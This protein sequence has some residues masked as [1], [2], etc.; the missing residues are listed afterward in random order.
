MIRSV[1]P[2]GP[3]KVAGKVIVALRYDLLAILVVA[4]VLLPLP[5]SLQLENS[6]AALSV[7]GIAA[8]V[9]IAFRNTNAYA[10]WWEARTLWGA[11]INDCRSM[12]NDLCAVDDGSPE[13][14]AVLDRMRRCQVR[15]AW[16]LAAELRGVAP[17]PGVTD[18][19]PEDAADT[20]ANSLLN[21]QARDVQALA[22]GRH[23]D[24]SARVMLMT[25]NRGLVSS[26]GGLERIRNQPIPVHYDLFIRALAW[27]FA[28]V[29][30][31]RLDG[32]GHYVGSIVVG[33]LL[34]A[35]FVVAERLG[36]FIEQP[37]S[38]RV[39]D[40]PMYRFCSTITANLLGRDHPLAVPREGDRA[41][42]WW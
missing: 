35:V 22:A 4:A 12:H 11:V 23:V 28:I 13:M 25:V 10:R 5:D 29:A 17:P 33:F 3:V 8:S 36:H 1:G 41:S 39:F 16:Q 40:L 32:S 9:F 26:Q 37:M 24:D 2:V 18:L 14:A 6:V 15:F 42:V 19:T 31:N 7:L 30:F 34:M 38:N 20:T 21:R 27:L